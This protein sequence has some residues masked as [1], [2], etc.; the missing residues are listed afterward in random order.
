MLLFFSIPLFSFW[1]LSCNGEMRRCRTKGPGQV[2]WGHDRSFQVRESEMGSCQEFQV[3]RLREGA[4]VEF[5]GWFDDQETAVLSG[6]PMD[7]GDV[8]ALLPE[9]AWKT[10]DKKFLDRWE[11]CDLCN[12]ISQGCWKY[13]Q[14]RL[15]SVMQKW[16]L[17]C[18][19][20]LGK[21]VEMIGG[22]MSGIL[23]HGRSFGEEWNWASNL[24]FIPY[25][26]CDHQLWDANQFSS[27]NLK[28]FKSVFCLVPHGK[29]FRNL[30]VNRIAVALLLAA[31]KPFPSIVNSIPVA[32]CRTTCDCEAD[33][34]FFFSQFLNLAF[35]SAG[36][37]S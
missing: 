32:Q 25:S 2:R 14:A 9:N 18:R 1:H 5:H 26:C 24:H 7:R 30:N 22:T 28:L 20:K 36:W 16:I 21:V 33:K 17:S 37:I 8:L 34:D 19:G 3:T 23:L 29:M 10:V 13:W 4:R 11:T 35:P 31:T 6:W 27:R 12:P 15:E